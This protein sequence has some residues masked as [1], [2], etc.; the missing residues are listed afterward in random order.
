MPVTGSLVMADTGQ[1]D[2]HEGSTQCRHDCFM[3]ALYST[4]MDL[5][6]YQQGSYA[7]TVTG[8]EFLFEQLPPPGPA[9]LTAGKD[10]S[11]YVANIMKRY[12]PNW[13][14]EWT[15]AIVAR[16]KN[17]SEERRVGKEC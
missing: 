17:R 10:V 5:V 4:G 13:Q 14:R 7:T 1:A 11:F 9:W 16:L 3:N 15:Q 12:G 2:T 6:G 8:R